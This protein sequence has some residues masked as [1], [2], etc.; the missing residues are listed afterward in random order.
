MMTSVAAGIAPSGRTSGGAVGEAASVMAQAITGPRRPVISAFHPGI[1]GA[2]GRVQD[3]ARSGDPGRS[4]EHTSKL[5][6]LMRISYAVFCLKK[7]KKT[8]AKYRVRS[9]KIVTQN[10]Q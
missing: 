1:A 2:R 6:S 3:D 4:E 5:Q 10:N 8:K 9:Q 7:K